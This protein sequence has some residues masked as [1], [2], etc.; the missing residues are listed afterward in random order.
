MAATA[1]AVLCLAFGSPAQQVAVPPLL[2]APGAERPVAL[3]QAAL[4]VETVGGLAR[5]RLDLVVRNPNAR[6]LE[7]SLDLPLAPGQEVV[8]FAL[9]IDGAMR[10]AVPVPKARGRQVFESI[11]RRN[12]DPALLERTAG[13]H[14]RLRVYPLPAG[15]TRRVRLVI[16]AAMR[17]EGDGWRLPLPV[18]V[19]GQVPVADLQVAGGAS[20]TLVGGPRGLR[21]QPGRGARSARLTAEA[22][23]IAPGLALDFPA[24]AGPRAFTGQRG[25][26]HYV[27]AELPVPVAPG[28]RRR[29]PGQVQLLWD[30]SA[31][32]R[33]R[34]VAGE[35]QLLDRYFRAVGEAEVSLRLLRD[36]GEDGGRFHVRGGDWQA[37]RRALAAVVYDGATNL[38]DWAPTARGGDVLLVSDGLQDYGD[39]PFPALTGQRLYAIASGDADTDRLAALA[40]ARG[41]RLVAWRGPAGL[42]Q[43]TRALLEEGM[44]VEALDG[45]GV[46]GLVAASRWVDDGL[47][48]IAG[49]LRAPTGRIRA[50]LVQGGQR[51]EVALP[52][53]ADAPIRDQVPQA[54]AAWTLRTLGE[55]PERHRAGIERLGADFGLVT[56]GTSLLV[57]DDP[58]D[59]VRYAI[60]APPALQAQVAG[61]ARD[62]ERL[63][64]ASR[65]ERV[66]RVAAAFAERQAWWERR[67]PK[68][69]P[70]VAQPDL[71]VATAA[72]A[73]QA[74]F[75]ERALAAPIAPAPEA[76]PVVLDMPRAADAGP[77]PPSP[78]VSLDSVVVA[79]TAD[80][81][82]QGEP[83]ASILLQPWEPDAPYARR[84]RDAPAGQL[85]ALYLDER[86]SHADSTAFYLDVAGLLLQRGQRALALRV[87]SNLA[88]LR[89]ENRHVLR[90][91]GYRLMQ[92]EAW[93]EAVQVFRQV[94][95]MAE[96]EPQSHR[97]LA[98]ALAAGGER[99]EAV[100]RLYDVVT[101][102]WDARFAEIQLVALNELNQIV[103]TS[104]RPLD[105]AFV[106]RRLLRNLPLDL[107]VALSWD[108]DNSDMD[109]WVTDPNGE[110]CYYAH[111]L[112]YQGGL[113]SDD[114][115]GGYG[116]EEFVLRD[117][118]PG[119]YIVQSHYFGDRQQIVTGATTLTLRLST[120]WGT[121]RQR[122]QVV[123]L[124]L[125]GKDE[126]VLVG[127]FEVE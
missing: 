88:E 51:R 97:D 22:L 63:R 79:G 2:S 9:D 80:A 21:L 40:E 54:W 7:G 18:S 122:D 43:A 62:A 107:R 50:T 104:P 71:Q 121:A 92:A 108:S 26:A 45:D 49:R 29:L 56:P 15:G 42:E 64:E 13:N 94:L 12:V 27:L 19:L 78:A 118:K 53:A 106:D 32:G 98:L 81:R 111:T 59:Y 105:T 33:R 126:T 119:R 47:L 70:P 91:L 17:R 69:A 38:S 68:D 60:P 67:F 127:E 30:A 123:T 1:A 11:A 90:V 16:D 103:A 35:L 116:P 20:A 10:D 87:L 100:R 115:T 85:Y 84:L 82:A 125:S 74:R 31:S 65:G 110:K 3:E 95:E 41:G 120:G 52:V 96:E 55:A 86:D 73:V 76:P 75:S 34:D 24:E 36:V 89:L 101:G 57:L 102:D 23:A 114:F 25:G 39:R 28:V 112:T 72:A 37:L 6:V 113:I 46:D 77:P 5:M 61:L 8:G 48:R 99:Q 58:A 93:P 44:R 14:F 109:L 124:R 83:V 66:E 4:A 117:A